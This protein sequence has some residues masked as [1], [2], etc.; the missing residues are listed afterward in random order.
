MQWGSPF[1]N[2]TTNIYSQ[3]GTCKHCKAEVLLTEYPAPNATG[4]GGA[5]VAMN[6]QKGA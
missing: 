6:C 2:A 4:I 5:A 3:F 1:G